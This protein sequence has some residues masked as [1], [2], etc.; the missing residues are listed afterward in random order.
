MLQKISKYQSEKK[1]DCIPEYMKVFLD[2]IQSEDLAYDY[3]INHPDFKHPNSRLQ[4]VC[5][6]TTSN[7]SSERMNSRA[8][9]LL[10]R[11]PNLQNRLL[12]QSFFL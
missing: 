9:K 3:W 12:A 1:L 11:A 7:S 6:L 10:V 4:L 2:G 8:L 5:L